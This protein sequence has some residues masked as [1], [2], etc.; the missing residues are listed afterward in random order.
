MPG[1]ASKSSAGTP[2]VSSGVARCV[3]RN[4]SIVY[5]SS[6][7]KQE[8]FFAGL[9]RA[10]AA[11]SACPRGAFRHRTSADGGPGSVAAGADR[12][13]GDPPRLTAG[14][15]AVGRGEEGRLGRSIHAR[16]GTQGS[17]RELARPLLGPMPHARPGEGS[18]AG[19]N[20]LTRR[21][22]LRGW[23][24][25]RCSAASRCSLTRR[26]QSSP[27]TK[28]YVTDET[29]E[30]VAGAAQ[31]LVLVIEGAEALRHL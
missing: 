7:L 22:G 1:S 19:P 8:P 23:R 25:G 10:P 9:A 14:P 16:E 3:G 28:T 17:V 21:A 24:R 20:C 11:R 18:R 29:Q 4:H 12:L 13:P 30:R 31:D 15:V 6:N 27:R 5:S 26:P 2:S